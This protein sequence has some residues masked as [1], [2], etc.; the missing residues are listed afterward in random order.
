MES[1][2]QQFLFGITVSEIAFILFFILL[3]FSF[4]AV[5]RLEKESSLEREGR[6]QAVETLNRIGEAFGKG[7]EIDPDEVLMALKKGAGAVEQAER[8]AQQLEELRTD[9]KRLQELE[10]SARQEA[11]KS[12]GQLQATRGQLANLTDWA[13]K[14]HPPC[15]VLSEQGDI[16]FLFDVTMYGD[17]TIQLA[18]AAS[19]IRDN[20]YFGLPSVPEITRGRMTLAEFEDLA[21]PIY[22]AGQRSAPRCRHFVNLMFDDREACS[23]FLVVEKYFYKSVRQND[24]RICPQ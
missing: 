4:F 17:E 11:A 8:Q 14:G 22:T 21:L 2:R 9:H 5:S 3:L 13:K 24:R 19:N 1:R 18:R 16:D 7:A 12:K 23:Y 10:H 15:W 6:A 20:E